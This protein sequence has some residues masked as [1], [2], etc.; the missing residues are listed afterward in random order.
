MLQPSPDARLVA[1]PSASASDR[2]ARLHKINRQ[3]LDTLTAELEIPQPASSVDSNPEHGFS[4]DDAARTLQ[5]DLLHARILGWPAVSESGWRSIRF[6]ED[7][8][9]PELGRFRGFR[10]I[11]GSWS[12]GAG[13]HDSFGRA[14]LALGETIAMAP[15]GEI[16]ERAGA[17]FDRALPKA[18]RVT[19]LRAQAS[20]VLACAAA[21]DA[22]RTA[23]M[24]TL[25]TDLHARFRSFA[26]PGWPWPEAELANEN[27]LLPR[28]LIVAGQTLGATT[29]MAVGLQVLDWLIEVQTAP[30]GHLSPIGSGGWPSG[31]AKARFDQLP[32]EATALLLAAEAALAATGRARYRPAMERAYGWFLGANDL[33][34]RVADPARG[35]CLDGLTADGP[36]TDEGAEATLMWLLALEH[37]RA[38]R[39]L[40]PTSGARGRV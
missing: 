22:P 33:G 26:Q 15:D 24:R 39:E 29:M 27:A 8:F 31:G 40:D 12:P 13:S 34:L 30:D 19:S 17:L 4:V 2:L 9:D 3:H 32:I 21:P 14:M 18:T 23:L 36:P 25:A 5:V 20:M 16:V 1:T 37:I 11:D 6:L 38:L 10:S 28:A 35:A 7:S